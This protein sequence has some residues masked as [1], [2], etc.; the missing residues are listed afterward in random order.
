MIYVDDSIAED[1]PGRASFGP[2]TRGIVDEPQGGLIAYV[3]ADPAEAR[4]LYGPPQR[5]RQ[6][7][8]R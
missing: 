7:L 1:D 4:R 6:G 3:H 8:M 2:P 5:H